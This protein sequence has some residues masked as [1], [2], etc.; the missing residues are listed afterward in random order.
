MSKFKHGDKVKIIIHGDWTNK[1]GIV[2]KQLDTTDGSEWYAVEIDSERR[3]GFVDWLE[4][5]E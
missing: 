2:I 4:K 1:I 5:V 3:A